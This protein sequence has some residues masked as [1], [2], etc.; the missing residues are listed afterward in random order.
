M[1]AQLDYDF[2][3]GFML[4]LAAMVSIVFN[5]FAYLFVVKDPLLIVGLIS[6]LIWFLFAPVYISRALDFSHWTFSMW[7]DSVWSGLLWRRYMKQHP[8]EFA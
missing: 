2:A 5:A 4:I 1:T 8:E 6:S 3:F 7:G